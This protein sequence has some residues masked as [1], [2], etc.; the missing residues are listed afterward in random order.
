MHLGTIL[1]N[2]GY[3]LALINPASKILLLASEQ[4]PFTKREIFSLSWRSSLAALLILSVF[5]SI[6]SFLLVTIFHVQI[7]SLSVAGGVIIFIVG[8]SAV[9]Q[10]K[11]TSTEASSGN[12]ITDLSI[13][14]LAAPLI[15]G[16]GVITAAIYATSIYGKN[17]TILCLTIALGINFILMLLSLPIG[18]GMEKVHATGPMIRITGLIVTAVAVQMIFSGCGTWLKV[19]LAS[20]AN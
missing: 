3:F 16:P 18:K 5:T 14:P 15:A 17:I 9:Q 10:G 6:G 13:V 20:I 4:P 7:Y 19:T 8:L 11:F 2:T 1:A 12:Q